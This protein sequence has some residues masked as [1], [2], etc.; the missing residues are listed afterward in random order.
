MVE[1]TDEEIAARVQSGDIDSFSILVSRYETKISRYARKFLSGPDDVKDIVQ[2]VFVKVYVNIK[3]FDVK[4]RFS[5]WIY[6]IAHNEFV[7]ALKKKKSEKLSFIDF[8]VLF[9]HPVASEAADADVDRNDLRRLLNQS[10]EK[11]P[12]KYREPLVL[13][14]FEEMSYLEIA[15]IMHLPTSTVGIRLQRAKSILRKAVE[16]EKE[17]IF[18]GL[19]KTNHQKKQ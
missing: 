8:D 9:P 6:R 3:S 19:W 17:D 4:Q 1:N 11:I 2:D 18:K 16:Q 5:P 10:L 12:A 13:Y 15:N 7:N 14:Y